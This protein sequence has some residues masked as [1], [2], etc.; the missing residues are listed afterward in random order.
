MKKYILL[1]LFLLISITLIGCSD[2]SNNVFSFDMDNP[3][4]I[5]LNYSGDSVTIQI[6]GNKINTTLEKEDLI[7][8]IDDNTIILD[9][10]FFKNFQS[11]TYKFIISSLN[12]TEISIKISGNTY[13]FNYITKEEIFSLE[14][15][16]FFCLFTKDNCSTCEKLLINT[17]EFN[18]FLNSYPTDY[19]IPLYLV[20]CTNEAPSN[21]AQTNL[22]GINNYEDLINNVKIDTPTLI[23]IENKTITSYYIG[24]NNVASFMEIEMRNIS[25]KNILHNIDDPKVVQIPLDFVPTKYYILDSEEKKSTYNVPEEYNSKNN[26]YFEGKMI[27]T[28]YFFN[29]R[30]PGNYKLVIY[31]SDYS[32]E[33]NLFITSTLTYINAKDIFNMPNEKYYI[34]F[35][36]DGCPGCNSVK[37]TLKEYTTKY[38]SYSHEMA[39]PLYAVH[40]SQHSLSIYG[41]EDNFL[42][43]SSLDD[44]KIS[45][46]PRVVLIENGKITAVY[47]YKD[48]SIS[49]QFNKI[50]K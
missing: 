4:P 13:S 15:D 34:F 47:K 26:G 37:P 50:M 38:L 39:Y 25:S 22:T 21:G 33:I 42:D 23:I 48:N 24:Y 28:T 10:T 43:V 14:K 20:D 45:F 17:K 36:Q 8:Y 7:E 6:K 41:N 31:N 11:G 19:I 12:T 9:Y 35:L 46:L 29:S 49:T 44:L 1:F 18:D 32:I 40:S 30:L 3:I 27:F 16:K 2:N 5:R